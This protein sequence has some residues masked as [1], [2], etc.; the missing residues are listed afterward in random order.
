MKFRVQGV[1]YDIAEIVGGAALGDVR[2]LQKV[3][4]GMDADLPEGKTFQ[5]VSPRTFRDLFDR[6]QSSA[7]AGDIDEAGLLEDAGFTLHMQA[8]IWLARRSDDRTFTWDAAGDVPLNGFGFIPEPGDE[9]AG[10]AEADPKVP[11][12]D[13]VGG[14]PQP[15]T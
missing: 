15:Q 8:L 9:G 14:D 5:G 7:A 3:T 2:L 4:K 1:D 13:P 6:L 11:A 10:E 12:S